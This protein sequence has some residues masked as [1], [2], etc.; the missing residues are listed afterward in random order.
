MTMIFGQVTGEQ[1]L[2]SIVLIYIQQYTL[3]HY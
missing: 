3:V 2:I 1:T